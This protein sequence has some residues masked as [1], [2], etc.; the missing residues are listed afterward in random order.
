MYLHLFIY[1]H[2]HRL[3]CIL[4]AYLSNFEN[5]L[6]LAVDPHTRSHEKQAQVPVQMPDKTKKR[7][8]QLDRILESV[9]FLLCE[10]R[11]FVYSEYD[12]NH[13]SK[14]R[15][16]ELNDHHQDKK[17]DEL[18]RDTNNDKITSPCSSSSSL[19]WDNLKVKQFIGTKED[20]VW[21]AEQIWNISIQM[22][23]KQ[24]Q[25][26]NDCLVASNLFAKVNKY[27]LHHGLFVFIRLYFVFHFMPLT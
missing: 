13:S 6:L 17:K 1:H 26:H 24:N 15:K 12:K 22:M 16:L 23:K 2:H 14:K 4:R 10:I 27:L 9:L 19:I 3:F 11:D 18:I 21:I 20:C 5:S 7:S 25:N 8:D